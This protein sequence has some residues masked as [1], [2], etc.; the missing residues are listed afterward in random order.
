MGAETFNPRQY[1]AYC[2]K[3]LDPMDREVEKRSFVECSGCGMVF[4]EKCR[5]KVDHCPQCGS[6]GIRNFSVSDTVPQLNMSSRAPIDIR[7]EY[8]YRSQRKRIVVTPV[9]G[10]GLSAL[11]ILGLALALFV[12]DRVVQI[13]NGESNPPTPIQ[14]LAQAQFTVSLFPTV[15]ATNVP[16]DMGTPFALSTP[17]V[18]VFVT[19]FS[20]VETSSSPTSISTVL[21]ATSLPIATRTR[22]SPTNTNV[23]TRDARSSALS[24]TVN[25]T[26][27]NLRTGP[28]PEYGDEGTLRRGSE[29][30]L[31]GRNE[32]G[33]WGQL[34]NL[35]WINLRYVNLS[36]N[37]SRL[38]VTFVE[39]GNW[40]N[41]GTYTGVQ[42][43]AEDVLRIRGGPGTS[44]AQLSNPDTIR[45]GFVMDI[46]GQSAN[47]QWFQINING[48]SGWVNA[49][50]VTLIEG[51]HSTIPV[52][53]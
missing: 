38:P 11:I 24:G 23:P 3:T 12:A 40:G 28:G 20:T 45:Q 37:V 30:M 31:I 17:T 35:Y 15:T 50:Y 51:N 46:V 19:P 42:G 6:V 7:E 49:E 9:M 18:S 44:Y 32:A 47:G 36:G 39:T 34:N 27:L 25:T 14:Q 29:V 10:L 22:L 26:E 21:P 2:F 52:V 48:R 53:R 13:G 4:H 1:C 8:A 5:T 41:P 43:R 16:K 33:T